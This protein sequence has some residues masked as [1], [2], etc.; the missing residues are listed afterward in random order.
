MFEICHLEGHKSLDN[1]VVDVTA[2]IY[3][4]WHQLKHKTPEFHARSYDT[5]HRY[6][7]ARLLSETANYNCN[8]FIYFLFYSEMYI[9]P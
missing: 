1:A 7:G 9:R 5:M 2:A 6:R 4:S 3:F 8:L